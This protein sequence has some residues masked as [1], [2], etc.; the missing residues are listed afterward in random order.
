MGC[1]DWGIPPECSG[2]VA[3]K[4]GGRPAFP[5]S[6]KDPV[7]R[8]V[9]GQGC[10]CLRYLEGFVLQLLFQVLLHLQLRLQLSHRLVFVVLILGL[11]VRIPIFRDAGKTEEVFGRSLTRGEWVE[12][13]C[14][15]SLPSLMCFSWAPPPAPA[16]HFHVF[17][18]SKENEKQNNSNNN[19]NKKV[20]SLEKYVIKMSLI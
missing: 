19:N 13:L 5:G 10:C 6:G 7:W 15:F 1:T 4:Q 14:P 16:I 2:K 3:K 9:E 17:L 11:D 8:T 18:D 12:F 20:W